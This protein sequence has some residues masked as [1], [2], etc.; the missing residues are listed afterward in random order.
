M[1]RRIGA[2]YLKVF[3]DR[4]TGLIQIPRL[5]SSCLDGRDFLVFWTREMAERERIRVAE[6]APIRRF[7]MRN[8]QLVRI[9]AKRSGRIGVR[10]VV[11]R[12]AW[13][14]SWR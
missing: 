9:W 14:R 12:P 13:A 2:L 5:K 8:G 11:V 10:R 3:R 7:F 4:M 6:Q 1:R